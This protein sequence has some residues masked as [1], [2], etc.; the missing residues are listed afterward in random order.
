MGL[1]QLEIKLEGADMRKAGLQAVTTA[2]GWSSEDLGRAG[3]VKASQ[4]LSPWRPGEN[5][6]HI[7]QRALSAPGARQKPANRN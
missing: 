5:V 4:G 6:Q 2:P 7:I 1:L 3:G